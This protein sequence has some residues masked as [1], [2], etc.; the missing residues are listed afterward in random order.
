MSTT[1][2]D[3][4]RLQLIQLDILHAF[5][6]LC[7][8]RDL[9]YFLLGGSALGAVRHAGFIPWDDDIDVGMPRPDYERFVQ[10]AQPLLPPHLFVQDYKSEP[11]CLLN[12]AKIR[13]SRTLYKEEVFAGL[14][15]HHGVYI[16]VFPL[17]G[18]PADRE[19][20]ERLLKRMKLYRFLLLNRKTDYI[21]RK[22]LAA[23]VG[24]SLLRPFISFNTC[25]RMEDALCMRYAYEDAPCIAN[26]HGAWGTKEV[27]PRE[28]FGGGRL[29]PFEDM[30]CPVPEDAD[31]YLKCLYGDY[32]T[33]PPEEKRVSHHASA[34]IK[35]SL[36]EE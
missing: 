14:N 34:E 36:D 5:D 32:Q 13:D 20:A 15:I 18:G 21:R 9:R 4:R 11:D 1:D 28:I 16:D 23:S 30:L 35:L 12:F 6:D 10:F 22:N 31:R 24:L 3:L 25:Y 7:K 29:V 8:S 33:L 2:I 17:D 26:W 27:V 19:E